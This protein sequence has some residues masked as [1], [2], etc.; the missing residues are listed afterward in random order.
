MIALPCLQRPGVV[1]E[2]DQLGQAGVLLEEIDVG[3]VVQVDDRAEVPGLDELLGGGVVG[4][5]H[6]LLAGDADPLGE[7]QLGQRAAVGAEALFLQDLQDEGIGQRLD[8]EELLEA[9][10]ALRRPP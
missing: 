9:L 7:H 8:G 2:A 6:D 5:E 10:D 4:G 1:A 3:D